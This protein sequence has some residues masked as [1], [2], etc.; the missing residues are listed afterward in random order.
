MV[1]SKGGVTADDADCAACVG[2][3]LAVV[4]SCASAWEAV[5]RGG[6]AD[7]YVPAISTTSGFAAGACVNAGVWAGASDLLL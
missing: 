5:T 1:T 3:L 2:G 6:G 4:A 7:G